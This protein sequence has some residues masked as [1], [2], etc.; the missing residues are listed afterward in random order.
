MRSGKFKNYF[1]L[2]VIALLVFSAT[3]SATTYYVDATDGDDG[4]AGTSTGTAWQNLSKVNSTTFSAGDS[5]L[6][7]CG[8]TWSGQLWPKGSGSSGSPII[9]NYYGDANNGYPQINGPGGTTQLA[10]V[11]LYCQQ[12]WEINNLDITHYDNSDNTSKRVGVF[13]QAEDVNMPG[14]GSV[15]NHIYLKNL[16]IH[17]I[18]GL[19][20]SKQSGG[21]KF[22]ASGDSNE[23]GVYFNDVQI[24]GCYIY[25]VNRTGIVFWSDWSVRTLT[26]NT[27]WTPWTDVVV[28]NNVVENTYSNGMIIRMCDSPLVEYNTFINCSDGLDSGNAMFFFNCDDAVAQFNE[29]YGTVYNGG[30]EPDKDAAAFDSDYQCK[31]TIFQYNYSHDNGMGGIV[32]VSSGA[33][34]KFNDGTVI[35][36]NI[37]EDNDRQGFRNTGG[38]TNTKVYNNVWYLGSGLS[39]VLI[40]YQKSWSGWP[41]GTKFYNNIIYNDSSN[42][43][44]NFGSATNTEF[45]YNV[46]YGNAASGEPSDSHKLTSDPNFVN[47]GSGGIGLDSVDGY[48]LNDGSPCINSGRV[49]D[50]NN[51]GFD[52]WANTVPHGTTMPDRGAYESDVNEPDEPNDPNVTIFADGFEDCF[53]NWTSTAYCSTTSYEGSKSAKMDS[54]DYVKTGVSTVGYQSIIV[55]YARKLDDM[56]SGDQF[57]AEWYDGTSWNTLE[58]ITSTGDFD[59]WTVMEF[60]I[61]DVDADDN[62][63]F[64]IRFRTDNAATNYAYVDAVVISGTETSTVTIAPE[65]DSYVRGGSSASNNYGTATSLQVKDSSNNSYKR[66]AYLRFD[67]GNMSGSITSATLRVKVSYVESSSTTHLCNFVSS[68]S[69]TET[70][71]NWNN[72]PSYGSQLDSETTVSVGNWVEFDVTSQVSTEI[73]GDDNFSCIIRETSSGQ[74]RIDYRSRDYATAADR[75]QL[76]IVR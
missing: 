12:Y 1:N 4:A 65:A 26:T 70:G 10:A 32:C 34:G 72:K 73:S 35:R 67:L 68:D 40:W 74:K 55:K 43:S 69:W 24:D 76:V 50:G 38:T 7:Q 71:I 3:A 14:G 58:S 44:Y 27:N 75:P 33:A 13:V 29:G 42:A 48:K 51:G 19:T 36:Y 63:D 61:T 30:E 37:F 57:V 17:N 59:D 25:D 39:N 66:R 15:L 8:E 6:F 47:V 28:K 64:E 52:Y 60:T 62:A 31:N 23:T 20:T 2:F 11:K 16:D 21:I 9:I 41:D 49:V 5:I 22:S 46:F 18:N 56:L 53:T 54:T 45:D